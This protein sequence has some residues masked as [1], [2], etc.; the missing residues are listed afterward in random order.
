LA[1]FGVL[2][3]LL[4]VMGVY[5]VISHAVTLRWREIGVRMSLGATAADVQRKILADGMRMVTAGVVAGL[6]IAAVGGR[7]VRSMLFVVN[8]NDGIT[9][10]AATAILVLAGILA[11][12]FP[13]LRATRVD[14]AIALRDE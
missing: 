13:A 8:P 3:L 5:G 11:C 1:A 2:A 4:A 9:F 14:P 7:A 6:I 10:L 12:W